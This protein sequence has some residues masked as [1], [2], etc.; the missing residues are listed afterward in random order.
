MRMVPVKGKILEGCTAFDV[1]AYI[2]CELR[3]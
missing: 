1:T 3:A 2:S